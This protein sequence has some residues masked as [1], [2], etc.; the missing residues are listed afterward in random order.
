MQPVR[1]TPAGPN[2]PAQWEVDPTVPDLVIP[3]AEVSLEIDG[4]GNIALDLDA[5]ITLPPAMIGDT[6]VVIEVQNL[7]F[8]FDANSTPPGQPAGTKGISI[9]QASVYLPGEL[10]EAV[11]PLTLSN[12]FI[13]NGGFTGDVATTFPGGLTTELFGLTFRLDEVQIGFVQNALTASR[14]AGTVTLPFFDEPVAVEIAINLNGSFTVRLGSAANG[15][16]T[17]TKPGLLEFELESLGFTVEDGLFT[18]RMSGAIRP[19]VGGL[20]WPGFRVEE[21]SI[22]SEG[23][24][25]V[26]G[27]W[28]DLRDQ[29]SL[30]FYGFTLEITQFGLGTEEDGTRWIGV[31]GGL[32]LVDGLKAGASVKG[33]RVSWGDD[34]VPSVSFEGVGVEFEVPDVLRFKGEVSYRELTVGAETV[35]RFDGAIELDLMCLNMTIDAKLVI[36]TASGPDGSYTFLGIYLGVDLPAGIP[37]WSTGLALY[38]LE[39]LFAL[40]MEPD[41]Q[42]DEPWYGLA[43]GE[44]WYKRPQIGVTD[45]NQKWVN[46]NRSLAVGAGITIG[47]LPDNGF[48]FNG[49]MLLAIVFPGPIIL[50]EGKA[51]ILKERA[52]LGDDPIFRALVVLDF[53]AGDFLVGLDMRYKVADGG[54]LIDIGASAEMYF[55]FSDPSAWHLYIGQKDPRERR[56][57]ARILSLF[58]AESYYMLDNTSIAFGS[59][60]GYDA[61]WRF[62][63]VR[64]EFEAW[65]E[66]NVKVSWAPAHFHGDLWAHGK[67]SI[68]V[69]GFGFGLSVDAYLS[70]DVFDPFKILAQLE[71][72]VNLPWPLPDFSVDI[73]LEWGDPPVWPLPLVPVKDVAIEHLKVGTSWALPRP[74]NLLEPNYIGTDGLRQNWDATLND[75]YNAAGAPPAGAPVVPLDCRPRITFARHMHDKALVGVM[76]TP[77]VPARERIGDPEADEG[78]V[79]VKYELAEVAIEAWDGT[80]WEAVAKKSETPDASVPELYGS[81]APIPPMPDGGGQTQGQTKLW[82]WSKNP[83][84]YT[85]RTGREWEDWVSGRYPD[86]PCIDIPEQTT[87][88][89]DFSAVPLGPLLTGEIPVYGYRWWQHPETGGPLFIWGEPDFPD[90]RVIGF[91]PAGD[92]RG[93][94]LSNT[95]EAGNLPFRNMMIVIFPDIP[96]NGATIHCLDPEGVTGFAYGADG[97]VQMRTGGTAPAFTVDFDLPNVRVVVMIWDSRMCLW[98]V[99]LKT[100]ASQAQIDEAQLIAQHNI[101]E[102]DRWKQ[103]GAVL[104]HDTDY[105]IR[106]LTRIDAVGS[107]PLNGTRIVEQTEYAFFRT[108]GAPGLA[109]LSIPLTAPDPDESALR[110][111]SGG[112]VLVDGAPAGAQRALDSELNDLSLYVDQTLPVTVPGK[113]EARPLPRPVY[114]GYDLAVLFNEDY[115]SQMYRMAARDLSLYVFDSNNRPVRDAAGRLIAI[116]SAWD[117]ASDLE[118]DH[119]ESVWVETV[120]ASTCAGID[121]TEIPHDQTLA[122]TGLVLRPDFVHQARLT[123]LL[124]HEFFATELALGDQASGT[125]A[126]VGRW[127]V[128]DDGTVSAPSVW[129]I[130]ET[131]APPVRHIEQTA[132]IHSEPVD[133]RFPAKDGTILSLAPLPGLAAGHPLQPATW[134]DYRV[135]AVL[136]SSDDDAL[137]LVFRRSGAARYYRFAMDRERSY[138]RLTRHLDGAVLIL[139]EDDFTYRT[140]QDY[141][142][143]IEAIGRDIAVYVDGVRVFRVTDATHDQGGIGLYAWASQGARFADIRVDDFRD[144][145]RAVY[146]YDFTTS[147]YANFAHQAHSYQDEVWTGTL[148][149]AEL[150]AIRAA[151]V[152]LATAP[153]ADEGRAWEA[154]ALQPGLAAL[155]AQ[156][157]TEVEVTRIGTGAAQALLI[158]CPEPLTPG[159]VTLDLS[160]SDE[161]LAPAGRPGALKLTGVTRSDSDPNAETVGLIVREA[162]DPSGTTIERRAPAGPIATLP[163]QP[164]LIDEDFAATAGVLYE[165]T[166][167]ALALDLYEIAQAGTP[168]AAWTVANGRIEQT[169]NAFDGAFSAGNLSKRGTEARFGA[170]DWTDVELTVTLNSGDDDSIGLIFRAQANDTFLRFELNG[171]FGYARLTHVQD[172]TPRQLWSAPFTLVQNRDYAL[173]I[174]AYRRRIVVFLDGGHLLD[175]TDGE[176]PLRG[177]AAL[178]CWANVGAR[179]SAIRVQTLHADPLLWSPDLADL[180]AFTIQDAPGA[181]QGPSDWSAHSGGIVQASNIHI[182]GAGPEAMGTMLVGGRNWTDVAVTATITPGDDDALGLCIRVAGP[183]TY[184]RFSYANQQNYRR[185]VKVVDGAVTTLWQQ[186]GGYPPGTSHR[187]T[188]QARGPHIAVW[189]DGSFLAEVTDRDIPSGRIALY[190]WAS[191]NARFDDLR[192]FDVARRLGRWQIVDAG[193][194]SGPSRWRMRGGQLVQSSNIHGGLTDAASP[195]KPGTMAI[196]GNPAWTDYRI[197]AQ[198][199]SDDDDA[200]GLVARYV[201]PDNYYY[202]AI[203]SERDYRRFVRVAEGTYTTLWTGPGGYAPGDIDR[204]TLDAIGDRFT[205]YLGDTRLF[206]VTDG[207]HSSGQIGLYSWANTKARFHRVEVSV[208]PLKARALMVDDFAGPGLGPWTPVDTGNSGGAS[209]WSVTGG[210]LRQDGN[211]HSTPFTATNPD[212]EGTYARAG[213]PAWDDIILEVDLTAED[214]DAMGVVFR[215]RDDQNYYRFTMD[216]ERGVR[217]LVARTAGAFTLLWQ[218]RQDHDLNRRYRLTVIAEG[219][220]LQG[221]LDGIPIFDVEDA[222]HLTGRVGL[223]CWAMQGVTFERL[224]VYP[225]AMASDWVLDEDFAVYRAFRWQPQDDGSAAGPQAFTVAD[226]SLVRTAPAPEAPA[227]TLLAAGEAAWTDYRAT[228]VLSADGPGAVGLDVRRGAAGHYRF[229]VNTNDQLRFLRI[230]PGGAETVLWTGSATIDTD[231]DLALSVDCL[232]ARLTLSLNGDPLTTLVDPG[233]PASGGIALYAGNHAGVRFR[234]ARVGLPTWETYYRF[235]GEEPLADGTRLRLRSGSPAEP[236]AHDPLETDRFVTDP[237]ASGE[238]RLGNGAIDLRVVGADGPEHGAR[239]LPDAAFAALPAR[240]L[241][242]ADGTAM[243]LLADAGS[244]PAGSYRLAATFRRD[245]SASDAGAAI[246]SEGGQTGDEVAVLH[247]TL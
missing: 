6:G 91:D 84:D 35:H 169:A 34:G 210:R 173:R 177:R 234:M 122:N 61:D 70:G 212:K 158:R 99:C 67:V 211:I 29:F 31:S 179:F 127:E 220:R 4:D 174:L 185:L 223:C 94:C 42:A 75:G 131:G 78:P 230:A 163:A 43:P 193:T 95:G 231:S 23:H 72:E 69:F 111:E 52:S 151:S 36:G 157:P 164:N 154:A 46:R 206:S 243:L 86:M 159:R 204:M 225:A 12:A 244:L 50:I 130:G 146:A 64:V 47:T 221:Y 150:A 90:V 191:Q 216:R 133:G 20:D 115:V 132:N 109:N 107:A 108:E 18:A 182:P 202:F 135:T 199:Q 118:L 237:F 44:G 153:G 114:R 136:R 54:E 53:R 141:T 139:A 10:G 203:D 188:L 170:P 101:T 200:I 208:P 175:L 97:T 110:D 126:R 7:D 215:L 239:F 88:C 138:R 89:W 25:H 48:T 26:D 178:W 13:G 236:T 143:T 57:R 62:G 129:R 33:L 148:P 112:F 21:L 198:L 155:L 214:D 63:P 181:T 162:H 82:L 22:D 241:S 120:N 65:M 3:F 45:I 71:I 224:R 49:A 74:A 116:D 37:L 222:S 39:G 160:H 217:Q 16:Y 149:G 180:A 98:E 194:V 161:P 167:G 79:N 19:L 232:G 14:I 242:K 96:N 104:K 117:V 59:W 152:P 140:G 165:E 56:V 246:L 128:Q 189:L 113:G 245:I 229:T 32:K 92:E 102:T 41:K 235:A 125:G 197:A 145:A 55:S 121:T 11:G 1:K 201:D 27:G 171:Q 106:I 207:A 93:I 226:G 68:S 238:V 156:A 183:R 218:S 8:H 38:G 233:G 60:V 5:G 142:V 209:A 134:T 123:P 85:R 205:G 186:G 30:D 87:R 144:A 66:T 184:Y 187:V 172:G 176:V 147:A 105:R 80:A 15:L 190:T 137:G 119:H 166:F 77:V 168:A 196:A 58:T 76:V 124:L 103:T 73:T 228:T 213:D 24:V 17:L 219:P 227:A 195:V 28:I 247:F 83:F 240:R 2:A 9:R 51:N 192:V 40:N 81:W 100:G